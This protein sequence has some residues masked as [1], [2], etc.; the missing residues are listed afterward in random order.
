MEIQNVLIYENFANDTTL[1]PSSPPTVCP[2]VLTLNATTCDRG[3]SAASI[4]AHLGAPNLPVRAALL[5]PALP[6]HSASALIT[7]LP[8]EELKLM[9][10]LRAPA[11]AVGV[12]CNCPSAGDG[13][14]AEE[15]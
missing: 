15:A 7:L 6:G 12:H 5:T 11:L 10:C 1:V 14:A 2:V 13:A 3:E 4:V 9:L 8:G